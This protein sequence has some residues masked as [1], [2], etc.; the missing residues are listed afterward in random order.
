MSFY[1]LSK[2]SKE[3]LIAQFVLESCQSSGSL[4][5]HDYQIIDFWL[6]KAHGDVDL[7]LLILS[8]NLPKYLDASKSSRAFFSLRG[9][10]DKLAKKIS[11]ACERL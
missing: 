2:L 9:L 4:A 7:V 1:D 3:E 11:E 10:R 5:Y 6:E 8:E